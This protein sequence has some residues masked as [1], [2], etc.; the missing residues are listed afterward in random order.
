MVNGDR[1]AEQENEKIMKNRVLEVF[2]NS[3]FGQMALKGTIEQALQEIGHDREFFRRTELDYANPKFREISRAIF[4][5]R[6][7]QTRGDYN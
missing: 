1:S 7:E 5:Y 2:R 3:Y 4:E 6:L